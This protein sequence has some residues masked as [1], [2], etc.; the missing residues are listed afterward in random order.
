MANVYVDSTLGNDANSGANWGAGGTGAKGTLTGAAAIDAA[1]DS[2]YVAAAHAETTVGS[3]TFAWA[4]SGAS[5]TKLICATTAAQPPTALATSG[6]A[7]ANVSGGAITYTGNC[8]VYGLTHI[9]GTGIGNPVVSLGGSNATQRYES[10]SFQLAGSGA[11]GVIRPNSGSQ[12]AVYWKNCT[13]KF[14]AAGQGL[15]VNGGYF[16]WNGGGFVAGGTN[17]TTLFSAFNV[18]AAAGSGVNVLVENVDFVNMGTSVNLST[19]PSAG[20]VITFRNCKLPAGWIGTLITAAFS[21]GAQGRA[22]MFNCD[23]GATN[24]RLWIEDGNGVI[25]DEQ[26]LIRTGG[27][28]DGTTGLSWKLVTNANVNYPTSALATPEIAIWNDTTGASK[29]VTVEV[30]RDSATN[31]KDNEIW[32]EV[33]YLGSSGTPVGTPITDQTANPL[34]AAA[35]QTASSVTWT[36]TGMA[37]PNKQALAV[38]FTPQM[39]GFFLARVMLAKASATVYVDPKVTVT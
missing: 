30:L 12:S 13:V 26:T 35:D 34:T 28:S 20:V 22:Q 1:G 27:A 31:L 23:T 8:Y 39:K 17:P 29:T 32:L 38:T 25:R 4:G 2:I 10:C 33:S 19:V 7:T 6:T 9:A 24:Y 21:A 11:A 3:L 14:A 37:N 16:N 15:N 36:T 5:T 18:G